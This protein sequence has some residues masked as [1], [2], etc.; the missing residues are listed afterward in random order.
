M[1]KTTF[2]TATE[3]LTCVRANSGWR[4]GA[5]GAL[6]EVAADGMRGDY[7]PATLVYRGVRV[8]SLATNL[9]EYPRATGYTLGQVGSGGAAPTGWTMN[10]TATILGGGTSG[11]RPYL[12]V[13]LQASGSFTH[14]IVYLTTTPVSP[15][16]I[17]TYGAYVQLR[18]GSLANL[19]LQSSIQF[20]TSGNANI[21][22][23]TTAFSPTSA[24]IE[25]QFYSDTQTAPATTA[26]AVGRIRYTI[27]AGADATLRIS[28]PQM[29]KSSIAYSPTMPTTNGTSTRNADELTFA[30]PTE[31]MDGKQ[32][33]FVIDFMPGQTA[34]D[35][36]RGIISIDDGTAQN[37]VDLYLAQAALGVFLT[38]VAGNVVQVAALSAGTSTVLARNTLRFSWGPAGYYVSL[39]GAPAVSASLGTAPAGLSRVRVGNRGGSHTT[40]LNGWVGPRIAYYRRQYT[41]V[42]AADGRTI[43]DC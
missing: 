28:L 31:W 43:R 18:A 42:A 3:L 17:I 14:T 19:A 32:G 5:T 34:G 37:R 6:E 10:N 9:V 15:G 8:E 35:A 38:A 29:W 30:N 11:A 33:T 21:S 22:F 13:R 25:T 24:D 7:N 23:A 2:R 36:Q 40:Y 4:V 26:N 12:D 41:D 27:A 20:R 16:E 1:P 39:N